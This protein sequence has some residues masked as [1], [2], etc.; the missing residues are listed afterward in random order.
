MLRDDVLGGA[1]IADLR[2]RHAATPE[3]W[4]SVLETLLHLAAGWLT[5]GYHD[6]AAPILDAARFELLDPYAKR[7][8]PKEYTALAQAYVFALGQGP[9]AVAFDRM[10]ELFR[11]M[12]RGKIT[13]T[14]TTAQYYSRFHLNLVESAIFAFA[15]PPGE[16]T[17][18]VSG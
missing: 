14:W 15:A 8:P 5:F 10:T 2:A 3:V 6:R 1:T 13:N 16:P 11:D 17:L 12:D 18:V 7:F 9:S 4:A